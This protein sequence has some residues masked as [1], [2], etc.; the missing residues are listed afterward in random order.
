ME[1]VLEPQGGRFE[2]IH[3]LGDAKHCLAQIELS[4]AIGTSDAYIS[5]LVRSLNLRI[6]KYKKL[7]FLPSSSVRAALL[8]K[9]HKYPESCKVIAIQMLKGGAA[10]TA[11]A[12]HLAMRLNQFGARVCLLDMDPQGN[13]S[14]YFGIARKGVKTFADVAAG[15][16]TLGEAL[17][18][19]AENLAVLPSNFSNASIDLVMFTQK[20]N[21]A[22]FVSEH[23]DE[24]R[25]HFDYIII[26]CNPS[27]SIFN[28]SITRAAD[29][30]ILP[31]NPD[32]SSIE[33][34]GNVFDEFAKIGK[35]D[36]RKINYKILLT[37][38]DLRNNTSR[39][40]LVKMTTEQTD[41]LYFTVI[42]FSND[43]AT[44]LAT[45]TSVFMMKN[46]V[47]REDYDG[48]TREIMGLKSKKPKAKEA[49]QA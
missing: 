18:P 15:N 7:S 45:N 19:V 16:C 40:Y 24:I 9:G 17:I 39:N 42:R 12:T 1:P 32:E 10:K 30:I 38:F 27:L 22:A 2:T 47:L 44:S 36:K 31:V 35:Q 33:S 23:I 21:P 48:L 20:S 5:Q 11:T 25:A 6:L 26:D 8:A 34:L 4:A 43:Y 28:A 29:E 13:A 14:S 49:G 3:Y 37:K 41:H 46:S